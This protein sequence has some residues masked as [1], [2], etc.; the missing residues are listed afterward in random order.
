MRDTS[1]LGDP[2]MGMIFARAKAT[3]RKEGAT[4]TGF[5]DVAGLDTILGDLL[6]LVEA[7]LR[8]WCL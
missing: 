4:D 1:T 8:A 3:A 2:E 6:E 5:A 7:R